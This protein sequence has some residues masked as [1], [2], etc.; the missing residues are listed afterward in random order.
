MLYGQFALTIEGR[1]P[2]AG[3]LDVAHVRH[4]SSRY[5]ETMRI[6]LLRG[7]MFSN[8]DKLGSPPVVIINEAMA[9]KYFPGED[10]LGKRISLGDGMSH[11]E[12]IGVVGNTKPLGLDQ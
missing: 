2:V 1:P 4:I 3:Q 5:F 12:I 11:G 8:T 6:P 10:P 9:A 7:R